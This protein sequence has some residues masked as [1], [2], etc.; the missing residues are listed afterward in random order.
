MLNPALTTSALFFST[1]K[2]RYNAR[3]FFRGFAVAESIP[4]D[5]INRLKQA[6]N[7]AMVVDRYGLLQ[8]YKRIQRR[9]KQG[10]PHSHDLQN[11]QQRLNQSVARAEARHRNLPRWQYP[12]SLPVSQHSD[13]IVQAIKNNQVVIIAGETGSGKTTQIPKMCLQAGY[14]VTGLIGHT[15]PRRL[16]AR[17][18][19]Q[20]IADEMETELGQS[21]G[22]KIRFQDKVSDASYIKLMTD[23]ILL[24][25]I[26]HDRH[27][28][29]YDVIIIDEAHERSLNIDFL[30]GYLKQLL[31]KRPDLTLVI[32]SAT[33][34][35]WRFSEFF[36]DAPVFEVSGRTYPVDILYQPLQQS[37]DDDEATAADEE[38]TLEDGILRSIKSILKMERENPNPARPGDMLVFL[39][40]EREIRQVADRL[41]KNGPQQLEV[42]PLYSRL[43]NNEQNRVFQSHSNRR[44][45]LATNVA[46]TS[47]TVPNIGYVIDSGLARIS[48]YSARAKVQRLPIEPV[49]Q[50]SANQ[51]AGRCGRVAEGIC[52]RLYSEQEFLDRDTFTEPEIQRTNLASVILMMQ[53]LKLG[54][55]SSFPFVDPPDERLINDGYRL[56]DELG[57]V[58]SARAIT[59][60]G[61]LLVKFPI[62][63]RIS[64][65]LVAAKEHHCL[66]EL[67]IIASG[68]S[69]QEP[70]SR[71]HDRQGAADESLKQFQHSD[72]DFLTYCDIWNQIEQQRTEL[73]SSRFRRWLVTRFLSYLRVREWQDVYRQLKQVCHQ[74]G[75]KENTTTAEYESVHRAILSGLLSHVA[76]K[77]DKKGYLASR[78]RQL[79]LFPG[80]ALVRKKP[81]WV[82][83]GEVVETQKVYGRIVAGIEPEWIEQVGEHA[84]KRAYFEPHW[85]K[86]RATTVAYEQTSLYGLVITPRRKINYTKIDPELCRE[87]FIR[88]ALVMGE[89]DTKAPYFRHNKALIDGVEYEE[90]KS[91]RRDILVDDE[92]LY[93]LYDQRIP[94]QVI[95]GK[96][97]EAWRKKVEREDPR[98]LYLNKDDLTKDQQ[99]AVSETEFPD[100]VQLEGGKLKIDYQFDPGKTHDGLN[101]EV[102]VTLLNQ[103]DE[104][105]LQWLVPGLE[106]EKCVA[107]IK[108]LPKTLRKNFVP[109]PDFAQAFLDTNPDR[110][111]SL[112]IQLAEF[113]RSRKAVD[114]NQDSWDR[115][116]WPLHLRANLRVLDVKGKLLREGRDIEQIKMG[117]KSEFQAS[118]RQLSPMKTEQEVH[119]HWAFGTIP[120]VYEMEQA[121]T[122]IKAYPGLVDKETGVSLQL[123]DTAYA[124]TRASE[125]GLLR[126]CLLS[127]P[128]QIR[129]LKKQH[130]LAEKTAIKYSPFG[131]QASLLAGLVESA[132]YTAFVFNQKPVRSEA[133]F[134]KRLS[135][136]KSRLVESASH[137][138]VL[139]KDI[140]EKHHDIMVLINNDKSPAKQATK[141]DV[142][143]QLERLFPK[144]WITEIPLQALQMYPRYLDAVIQRWHRLQGK[145]ERDQQCIDEL[146]LLW[147]QYSERAQK[148]EKDGVMDQHLQE[149]RWALEEYRISLFAQGM[150]TAFPVSHKRLQQM[151]KKVPS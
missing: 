87:T 122:T 69:V 126:L 116:S 78:N 77:D 15:Q 88:H 109:A 83:C 20:R 47:I 64:R 143:L 62:D 31:K 121:N 123:F 66:H 56:L 54:D 19:A 72:S 135:Q 60:L 141:Q 28:N 134:S 12:E 82:M 101:I 132:F 9:I 48:R 55:I 23:G 73:S 3:L 32:T 1:C 13:E 145:I 150:K 76:M 58:D 100:Q 147:K 39:S 57:A 43:S 98:V 75:W 8:L 84:L 106:K 91:R 80:S 38:S 90:N 103:V 129:Y 22:F 128:Q 51:R 146:A 68:L 50:A 40:G 7:Q 36:N 127:L 21:V 85:E 148:L 17:S 149:W 34:D 95:N 41:R 10:K 79:N 92:R 119:D 125:K 46:E 61:K 26:A 44:V 70:W 37:L 71:P 5:Q 138:Q 140:L 89:Y 130:G 11:F 94:A 133:D 102:P 97:F 14:G 108:S 52:I 86:K 67:L 81:K 53:G 142:R 6:I 33:I 96:S 151:W 74:L 110:S 65:M 104:A 59:P 117:L 93:E 25:E 124:A 114:V 137:M 139:L 111:H 115:S 4:T 118:L 27:L 49:S 35:H 2:F 29:Q 113:L 30:L 99:H 24:A 63:P 131:D 16:A 144:L 45:V 42:I 136:G 107:M 18:V 105:K 120:E 112:D